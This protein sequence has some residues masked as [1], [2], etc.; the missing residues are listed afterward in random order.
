MISVIK[1]CHE[2]YIIW[3]LQGSVD[4]VQVVKDSLNS[5][6]VC[7]KG[8][9][10]QLHTLDT[11]EQSVSVLL[12]KNQLNNSASSNGSYQVQTISSIV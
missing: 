2:V 9:D 3:F 7:F 1:P 6:R 10:S 12:E 4:D 8:G 11:L 5:L